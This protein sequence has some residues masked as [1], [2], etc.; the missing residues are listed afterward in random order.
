MLRLSVLLL[1]LRGFAFRPNAAFAQKGVAVLE[2]E[3]LTRNDFPRAREARC[4][5]QLG[6]NQDELPHATL[7]GRCG[8][9]PTR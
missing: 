4:R 2:A 3:H 8:H 1:A 7:Q 6:S 5:A 9:G